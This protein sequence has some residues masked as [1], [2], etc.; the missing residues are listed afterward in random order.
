MA[1]LSYKG[2]SYEVDS[3]NF[4]LDFDQWDSDFAEGMALELNMPHGLTKEH[5]DIIYFIHNT[6]KE[7]GRCPLVYETCQRSGFRLKQLR[8]LFPTG[9]LRGACKLAGMSSKAGQL[10]PAY[11][12][13]GLPPISSFMKSYD[14]TYVVDVRGFLVNPDEWDEQYAIYQAYDMK[15]NDGKLTDKH[16][17]IIRFLRESYDSKKRVPTVYET[18]EANEIDIEELERLFPGGYHRCLIKIAGLRV[19]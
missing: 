19:M 7:T 14:K 11:Q 5:W 8:N 17:Q 1:I 13:S 2:K 4:L 16:W 15:I 9:Y 6:F 12:P 3:N 18:C 10:G